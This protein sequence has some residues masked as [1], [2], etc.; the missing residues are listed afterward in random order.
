M[1]E[2]C[3]SKRRRARRFYSRKAQRHLPGRWWSAS[4]GVHV[5][6]ESWLRISDHLIVMDIDQARA[7][8]G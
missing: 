1:R 6:Y 2:R 8:S 4:D 3:G 5:G 7:A